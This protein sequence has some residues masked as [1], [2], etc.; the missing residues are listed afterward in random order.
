M[1]RTLT[2]RDVPEAVARALRERARRNRR[3]M[4]KEILAIL[5]SA[6]LDRAS[7]AEQLSTLRSRLGVRMSLDEIHGAIEEGW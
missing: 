2:L 1:S 7:L 4:Q 5:Q 6:A 3:S